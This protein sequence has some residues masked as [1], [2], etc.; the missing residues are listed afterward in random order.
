MPFVQS[1]YAR[2][3][4]PSF[5]KLWVDLVHEEIKLQSCS[6]QQ[7]KVDAIGLA[8]KMKKGSKKLQ[9]EGRYIYREE[10]LK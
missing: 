5:P 9:E 10:G 4:T 8:K 3:N 6:E 7:G 1:V 2:E